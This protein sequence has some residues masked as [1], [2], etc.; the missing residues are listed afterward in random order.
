MTPAA[1]VAPILQLALA[2][3]HAG[4]R[5]RVPR[6]LE[7]L[8]RA[9]A[10]A[11]AVLPHDSIVACTLLEDITMLL[12]CDGAEGSFE[13]LAAHS[14]ALWREDAG[15]RL[16]SSSLRRLDI[17]RARWS[18]GSLFDQTPEERSFLAG[19]GVPPLRA[20]GPEMLVHTAQE[21]TAGWPPP[22]TAADDEARLR[23]VHAAL[24]AALALDARGYLRPGP[25]R[26]ANCYERLPTIVSLLVATVLM[27]E[28]GSARGSMLQRMRATCGLSP[29]DESTLQALCERLLPQASE[30]ATA[31]S[32]C[33]PVS[34]VLRDRAA[35]DVA[36]HGLRACALPA[37]GTTESHPKTYKLCGRCRGAAYCC[38]QHSK[39]DWKRHK[40][41]DGCIAAE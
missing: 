30:F 26:D 37:C 35:A 32:L 13:D 8:S 38:A 27:D 28:Q 15:G 5:M 12:Q 20:Q 17:L 6:A 11:D 40:R 29:A 4:A 33:A 2:A 21:S 31:L 10:A 22:R 3:R 19:L 25:L 23:G 36:R 14:T 1:T 34:H 7:L 18:A 16:M 9:L 39:E 24:H 41:E